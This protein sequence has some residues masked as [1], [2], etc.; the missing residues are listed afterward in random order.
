MNQTAVLTPPPWGWQRFG[1]HWC[2]VGQHSTRPIVLTQYGGG[3]SSLTANH[4]L[5]PFDPDHPDAMTIAASADLLRLARILLDEDKD[6]PTKVGWRECI[7]VN[8][9]C[10]KCAVKKELADIISAL[11]KAQETWRSK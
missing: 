8:P 10:K 4:L 11:D 6:D 1:K 5:V 2:L 9:D 7:R 3:L